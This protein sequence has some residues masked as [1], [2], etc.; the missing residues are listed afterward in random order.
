MET[1]EMLNRNEV[2]KFSSKNKYSGKDESHNPNLNNVFGTSEELFKHAFLQKDSLK[3]NCD[4]VLVVA[5]EPYDRE[6]TPE[7]AD[8]LFSMIKEREKELLDMYGGDYVE[9]KNYLF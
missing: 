3:G 2:L 1:K 4:N 9:I 8:K 6:P 5:C 7:E